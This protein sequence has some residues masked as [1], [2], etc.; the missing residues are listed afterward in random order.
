MRAP[1][2]GSESGTGTAPRVPIAHSFA[3]LASGVRVIRDLKPVP[4]HVIARG[5]A[6]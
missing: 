1:M 6:A 4:A 2:V 3:L 5:R